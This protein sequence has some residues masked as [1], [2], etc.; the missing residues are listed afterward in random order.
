MESIDQIINHWIF[1]YGVPR[2]ILS[3]NGKAFV[4]ALMKELNKML[5]IDHILSSPYNPQSHGLVERANQSIGK[6]LR[7]LIEAHHDGTTNWDKYVS[8]AVFA[9][10]TTI[11]EGTGFS[12]YE[13][14]YGRQVSYPL[15]RLLYDDE[16][17]NS[18]SEYMQNLLNKQKINYAIVHENLLHAKSKN[19]IYN[20]DNN[21]KLR[22][23]NVGDL[24]YKMKSKYQ[25]KNK[26][27]LLYEGPYTIVKKIN[28]LCYQMKLTDSETAPLVLANIRQLKPYINVEVVVHDAT[29]ANKTIDDIMKEFREIVKLRKPI[30]ASDYL[31]DAEFDSVYEQED[32]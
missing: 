23:F 30:E 17:F 20:I 32:I 18:V 13:L 14:V 12:P 15:D 24:V 21:E 19:E 8:H 16:V 5:G 4:N 6:V 7:A 27:D 11:N 31:T 26:L 22:N 2:V 10:N 29:S 28:N 3:D 1:N 9:I 25:R